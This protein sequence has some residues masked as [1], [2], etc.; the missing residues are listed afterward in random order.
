MREWTK[1]IERRKGAKP[2]LFL[3]FCPREICPRSLSSANNFRRYCWAAR[4]GVCPC[5]LSSS[6]SPLY[7]RHHRQRGICPSSLSSSY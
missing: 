6:S 1:R 3:G 2:T 7:C 4:R 5:S